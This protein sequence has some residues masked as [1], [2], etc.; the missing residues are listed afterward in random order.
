MN[1]TLLVKTL[2]SGQGAASVLELPGYRVELE[3]E[4]LAIDRLRM[5][6]TMVRTFLE[7]VMYKKSIHPLRCYLTK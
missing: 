4:E 3:S 2:E 1:L 6:L 5:T 7:W